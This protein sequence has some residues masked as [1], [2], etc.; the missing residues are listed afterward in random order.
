MSVLIL[1][2]TPLFE[3]TLSLVPPPDW[4]AVSHHEGAQCAFVMRADSGL[5]EAVSIS[6][7]DDYLLGGEYDSRLEITGIDSDVQ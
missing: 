2:G 1:P 5:M 6:D 3:Q 7:L 4:L